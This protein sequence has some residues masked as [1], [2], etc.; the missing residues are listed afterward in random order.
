MSSPMFVPSL[1]LKATG[2]PHICETN[3]PA[4]Q[5]TKQAGIKNMCVEGQGAHLDWVRA[6]FY[7]PLLPKHYNVTG[8]SKALTL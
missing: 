5:P 6:E 4:K 8:V 1:Q 3:Q 7:L 2:M